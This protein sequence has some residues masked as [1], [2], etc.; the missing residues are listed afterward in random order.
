MDAGTRLLQKTPL[1][2]RAALIVTEMQASARKLSDQVAEAMQ[3]S[4]S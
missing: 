1:N 3:S 2:E 4:Q